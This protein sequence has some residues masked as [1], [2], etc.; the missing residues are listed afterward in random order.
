MVDGL[1]EGKFTQ[2]LEKSGS[3]HFVRCA[4]ARLSTLFRGPVLNRGRPRCVP[5]ARS[6]FAGG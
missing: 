6:D 2:G 3:A 1:K 4:R 5:H